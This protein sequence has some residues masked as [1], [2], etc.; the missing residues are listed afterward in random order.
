V[1]SFGEG[2]RGETGAPRA[3]GETDRRSFCRRAC[4]G[5]TGRV[6]PGERFLREAAEPGRHL[7]NK[8]LSPPSEDCQGLSEGGFS[9]APL[10]S[11][12]PVAGRAPLGTTSPCR[13]TSLV[14]ALRERFE[15]QGSDR[16][17]TRFE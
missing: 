14:E 10:N 15:G 3:A 16:A 5:P 13:A 9:V 12:H 1:E 7:L 6:C 2:G 17:V 4:S 8:P 11:E